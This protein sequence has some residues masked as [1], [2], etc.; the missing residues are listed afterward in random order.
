MEKR[1]TINPPPKR[2]LIIAMR[3]LGDVLLATPLIHS[4]RLA[5]SEAQIDVLIYQ[6]TTAMLEGNEDI[7]QIIT[8]PQH[9][10]IQDNIKLFKKIFR[11]YDLA[12]VTQTGDRPRLSKL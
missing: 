7:D 4:L 10:D 6:N 8:T 3:F 1:I 9:P 2:I 11:N 12:V 5:Y